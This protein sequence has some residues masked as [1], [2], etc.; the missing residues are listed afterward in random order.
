MFRAG[1]SRHWAWLVLAGYL[2]ITLLSWLPLTPGPARTAIR[3]V[4]VTWI[5]LSSLLWLVALGREPATPA[6]WNLVKQVVVAV[7]LCGILAAPMLTRDLWYYAAWARLTASGVDPYTTELP[8]PLREEFGILSFNPTMPYGP[9]WAYGAAALD[10]L[11]APLGSS[12]ELMAIKGVLV[13]SWIAMI[14]GMDRLMRRRDLRSRL[15]GLAAMSVVPISVFQLVAEAHNDVVVMALVV[16]WLLLRENG[17]RLS[18]IPLAVSALM[19]YFTVPLLLFAAVEAWRRRRYSELAC[20]VLAGSAAAGV[21]FL[22]WQD[23]ALLAGLTK[24]ADWRWLSAPFAIELTVKNLAPFTWVAPAILLWRVVLVL[25]FAWYVRTW[26]RSKDSDAAAYGMLA[27]FWLVVLMSAE[28]VWPW[29]LIWALPFVI[30]AEDRFLAGLAWPIFVV[31]PIAHAG[32]A[33]GQ[34][35]LGYRSGFMLILFWS[36]VIAWL[37]QA[38]LARARPSPG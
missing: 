28:Y 21:G 20:A 11:V 10:R 22:F 19:K 14:A 29:Y 16:W 26:W 31:L 38:W 27:A 2:L 25:G 15:V 6:L 7:G 37:W 35:R 12:V 18:P 3:V 9:V 23:G 13:A 24:N 1:S 30:L 32:W 34:H 36:I 5:S 17:S 8:D 33:G 4:L